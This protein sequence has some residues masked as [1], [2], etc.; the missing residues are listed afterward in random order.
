[1]PLYYEN[2]NIMIKKTVNRF[3]NLSNLVE[4]DL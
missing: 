4:Y 2:T 1:M 3:H